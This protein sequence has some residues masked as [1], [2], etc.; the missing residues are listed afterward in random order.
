[1]KILDHGSLEL[2]QVAGS[3]LDIV[4]AARVSY[5]KES[6]EFCDKDA[7]LINFLL[8]HE[9]MTPFEMVWTKWRI[10]APIFVFREWH[11]HRT[12]SIN[13]MS[14]RYTELKPEFYV[15]EV[16][17]KQVGKA[18]NYHYENMDM[19]ASAYA[20][21]TMRDYNDKAWAMYQYFLDYG[22]AKE[23]ARLVLPVSTYSEM[24]WA[25]NLRN[26]MHFIN[27]RADERAQWE[28]R[29]YAIAMREI[30]APQFPHVFV[31][32]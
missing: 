29:Q 14:G 24:I 9:H 17:R 23:Q 8:R 20:A 5:G 13:E 3:E 30:L 32:D 11:R 19:V 2:L 6:K 18:G 16:S 31:V 12:A 10:K 22:M 27:L 4:N 28:I 7:G 21:K 26:L 25:C 1:M 15:P